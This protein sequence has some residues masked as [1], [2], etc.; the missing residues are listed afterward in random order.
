VQRTLVKLVSATF[1]PANWRK[2][3]LRTTLLASLFGLTTGLPSFATVLRNDNCML[4]QQLGIPLYVWQDDANP[5]PKLIFIAI[6]GFTQQGACFDVLARDLAARGY[7]V[8]APDLRGHGR[9]Y[10]GSGS[11]NNDFNIS[12]DDESRLLFALRRTYPKAK[13]F[14]MGESAGCA[15]LLRAVAN[16]PKAVKGLIL[17]AAGVQ[18]HMH[19]PGGMGPAFIIGM[20]KL[21]APVDLTDYY[22]KYVSDDKRT[23]DE[24]V[25]DPLNRSHQSALNL[26]GTMNFISQM[27]MLAT[28]VPRSIPVLLLQ[29]ANDQI[30]NADSA[31]RVLNGFRTSDKSLQEIAGCGHILLGTAF[32]K[33]IVLNDTFD[34]LAK[35]GGM[36]ITTADA[37]DGSMSKPYP[38]KLKGKFHL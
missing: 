29:G 14:G 19:K 15:V 26:I 16:Q 35:H 3:L 38:Q 4:S 25:H 31:T 37:G 1:N 24:M 11:T 32:I 9:W 17:C 30:V 33:P 34:W 13:I 8:V 20:A 7:L 5:T 6:H 23:A 28:Q 22:S 18:P 36:P 2:L 10:G 27:P 21:V 12:C